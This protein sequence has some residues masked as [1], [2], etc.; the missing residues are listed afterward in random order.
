MADVLLVYPRSGHDVRGVSVNAPMALL[1]LAAQLLPDFSVQIIDQRACDDFWGTVDRAV[2]RKPLLVGVTSMT[3]TQIYHALEITKFI[4]ERGATPVVWGGMHPTIY[5]AQTV[6]KPYIDFVIRGEGEFAIR[7]LVQQL[8]MPTRSFERV[9]GLVWKSG[10]GLRAAPLG[11]PLDMDRLNRIPWH[12]VD[13]E[14]YVAPAQYSYPGIRRILPFQASRGCPFKCTFC[15]EPILTRKY[16]MMSPQRA[17]D[18]CL[19]MV[20][21]FGLD[22]IVFFDEEFFVDRKWAVEV[23]RRIGGRFTWNA[24]TR[25]TDLLKVDLKEMERCGLSV[26]LPGLESGSDRLL[27]EMKKRETVSDYRKANER[28]ASTRIWA[29]YNFIVGFPSETARELDETVDLVLELLKDNPRAVV[30]QLSPLTP[31]P[32]TE[33]LAEAVDR[34]GFTLPRRLEEWILVTRGRQEKPWLNAEMLRRV[35]FLYYTSLFLCSAERYSQKLR[36]PK[37][38]FRLYSATIRLRWRRKW[39]RLD[40][41]VALLRL[42]FR[43]FIN[44]HDYVF[45]QQYGDAHAARESDLLAVESTAA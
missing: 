25:A 7:A 9:P 45:S 8:T 10:G 28:L 40:W 39:Y 33:L 19:E 12:L 38:V 18:E 11:G 34:Y 14:E 16:R 32:G 42:L 29:Q 41:D 17:V 44:P 2:D 37:W 6:A 43:W 26:I 31:L 22:H 35:R 21:R 36:I 13:I 1:S 24:Q 4:R 23:A 27:R 20:R 3:G 30:N 15:S 5:P